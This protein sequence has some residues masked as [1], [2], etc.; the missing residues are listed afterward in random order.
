MHDKD[1]FHET[2]YFTKVKYAYFNV[3]HILRGVKDIILYLFIMLIRL[4]IYII[5]LRIL[6]F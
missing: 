1:R 2:Q 3:A 6:Q 4:I 5:F